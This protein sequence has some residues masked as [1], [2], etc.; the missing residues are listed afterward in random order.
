MN[1][2]LVAFLSS[3]LASSCSVSYHFSGC[4][5]LDPEEF[6]LQTSIA[7]PA[8]LFPI[9]ESDLE[10]S[11]SNRDPRQT[12]RALCPADETNTWSLTVRQV[13]ACDCSR[14]LK[15]GDHFYMVELVKLLVGMPLYQGFER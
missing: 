11:L 12:L 1:E 2:I 14:N 13:V 15:G 9:P 7:A 3:S 10:A 4:F 6:H 5:P 8:V